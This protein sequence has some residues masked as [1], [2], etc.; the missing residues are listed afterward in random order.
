M[1]S[2]LVWRGK[3]QIFSVV[4]ANFAMVAI[5]LKLFVFRPVRNQSCVER[6]RKGMRWTDGIRHGCKAM[7]WPR[8]S[9]FVAPNVRVSLGIFGLV[10]PVNFGHVA[11][12]LLR[13][14]SKA[15]KT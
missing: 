15:S 11:V 14:K 9:W 8:R 2:E 4:N 7:R 12:R 10:G 6:S 3:Q 1:K 13:R 5:E